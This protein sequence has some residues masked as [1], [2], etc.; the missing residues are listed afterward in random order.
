MIFMG[1]DIQLQVR[2]KIKPEKKKKKKK[3]SVMSLGGRD[4]LNAQLLQLLH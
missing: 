4:V 1:V 3:N 2:P